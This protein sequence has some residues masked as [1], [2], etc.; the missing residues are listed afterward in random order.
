[1]GREN[2]GQFFRDY[3]NSPA[4][5]LIYDDGYRRWTHRYADVARSAM[6]FA[7][8]LQNA[9]I[10]KGDRI[11]LWSENRPE[12]L[13]AFWGCILAGVVVVPI[14]SEAPAEFVR[15]IQATIQPRLIV[16]GDDAGVVLADAGIPRWQLTAED[17]TRQPAAVTSPPIHRADV[18][19]IMFTSGSTAEPKGVVITHGNLLSQVEA[20]EPVV[21]RYRKLARPLSPVRLLQL[22][23]LSHMFGQA[24]TLLLPPL[25]PFSIVMTRAQA[26]GA[27]MDQIRYRRVTAAVCIPGFLQLLQ[28]HVERLVPEAAGAA[29]DRSPLA[30]RLWRYRRVHW[31]LGLKCLGF[32]VGGAALEQRTEDFWTG[33]GYLIVQGYGLTETSPVVTLNHPFQPRRGSV[34]KALPGVDVKIAADGE[35]LVR[36]E[37]VTP[38]YYGDPAKTAEAIED[39]WL[40]TGDL[41]E[42]DHD[43]HLYIRGRKKEMIVTGEGLNVFPEDVERVVSAQY[44]VRE[45]AVV[46]VGDAG[47]QQVHAVLVLDGGTDPEQIVRD[48]NRQLQ[49]YQRIRSFSVWP[50]NS[51]P[52]TT[53]TLKL[54]RAEIAP[55][56]T[57]DQEHELS[58]GAARHAQEPLEKAIESK[59]G[60]R[61][62]PE[63]R[64]DELGLG[65]VDR[66]EL[67]L[68]LEQQYQCSLDER[69]FAAAETVGG[70]KTAIAHVLDQGAAR[71]LR[72]K[73]ADSFPSWNRKWVARFLRHVNLDFWILPLARLLARPEIA[74]KDRLQRL[75]PPV[76]FAGNHQSHIDTPLIL[77]ALP[78]RWRHRVAPAMYKEYFGQ[79]FHPEGQPL[80]RRMLNSLEYY[81]VALLFNA[82]PIPQE[83]PGA[84]ETLR[85]AGDLVSEGWSLLIF[86]EG[87][88]RASGQMGHFRPGVGLLA[89]RLKLPV[90]PIH[91]E[92]T[93]DVL[94][95]GRFFPHLGN[96]RVTFGRPLPPRGENPQPVAD[97][98]E[99]AVKIL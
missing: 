56:A 29:V 53:G 51:L 94:P 2:L 13:Y 49:G 7:A 18:A 48:A 88:R 12:W 33:L 70:L 34:G 85:Y 96:A 82:F 89:L 43:G 64:I 24:T 36:G 35:I 25:V 1:M 28:P 8:H 72:S 76:I 42:V 79:Y 71:R 15:K 46:A 6:L 5:Y 67:L 20:A 39:G 91:I 40:H 80:L 55:H 99:E 62:G 47:Q 78:R 10:A 98:L 93:D 63:A 38:G 81:L 27:V 11:I 54:K 66:V 69:E 84:R 17:W 75:E 65:S 23:P 58:A 30:L 52:R 41:G 37:N 45:S 83:E 4:E 73:R 19:E 22:L 59:I 21:R 26:P 86:P 68:E 14:G 50:W 9:G 97:Q 61:V 90:I 95:R 74:G 77:A 31:L 57:R 44:G 87:E 3:F 16:A 92:G 60:R 32:V